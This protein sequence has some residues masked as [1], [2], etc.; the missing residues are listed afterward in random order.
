MPFPINIERIQKIFLD[1]C[2]KKCYEKYKDDL[3][4]FLEC[5]DE[6]DMK[7]EWIIY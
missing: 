2:Y 6:C 3:K 7:Y 1:K 4:K 5:T